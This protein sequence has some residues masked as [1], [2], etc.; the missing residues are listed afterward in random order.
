[1]QFY[2]LTKVNDELNDLKTSDPFL[3]PNADASRALEII[4]VH[5]NMNHE[6]ERD[7]NP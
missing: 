4:P 1:M 5:D 2:V 6:V 3:P 7:G